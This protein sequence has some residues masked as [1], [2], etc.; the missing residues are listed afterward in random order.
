[1]GSPAAATEAAECL[2]SALHE[3]FANRWDDTGATIAWVDSVR[4]GAEKRSDLCDVRLG[5]PPSHPILALAATSVGIA[6]R[7]DTPSKEKERVRITAA[8]SC[9]QVAVVMRHGDGHVNRSG[10]ADGATFATLKGWGSFE[11]CDRCLAA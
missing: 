5:P 4:P 6:R 8:V 11:L 2:A 3:V 1:M 10:Q 7:L 9:C